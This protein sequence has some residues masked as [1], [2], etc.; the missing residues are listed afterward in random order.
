MGSGYGCLESR[1]AEPVYS[2]TRDFDRQARQE[3]SHAGYVPVILAGLIGTAENYVID[4]IGREPCAFDERPDGRSG[5]II[6]PEI[7]QHAA[8][9]PDRSADGG[10]DEGVRRGTSQNE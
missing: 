3:R 1:A 6:W 8:R 2:L 7:C 5:Q 10:G 9:P 4:S